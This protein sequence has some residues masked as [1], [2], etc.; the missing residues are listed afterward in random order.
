M[1]NANNSQDPRGILSDALN[2]W[3]D[4][5]D[6]QRNSNKLT[7]KEIDRLRLEVIGF[8]K[9]QNLV[10]KETTDEL[11]KVAEHL[12]NLSRQGN[13]ISNDK[14]TQ[15]FETQI[16]QLFA[17]GNLQPS[18]DSKVYDEMK[19]ALGNTAKVMLSLRE[20][21]IQLGDRISTQFK[22]LPGDDDYE[23]KHKERGRALGASITKLAGSKSSKEIVSNL[24]EVGKTF[25]N[26]LVGMPF[27]G[28]LANT[29]GEAVGN[30]GRAAFGDAL[31]LGV[32]LLLN[33]IRNIVGPIT[34]GI[35]GFRFLGSLK[36]GTQGVIK[37]L[38]DRMSGN[39]GKAREMTREAAKQ[40]L[41]KGEAFIEKGT[42]KVMQI[43]E[44]VSKKTGDIIKTVRPAGK[45]VTEAVTK[46]ASSK[47]AQAGFKGLKTLSKGGIWG[48]IG[49]GATYADALK[50][51]DSKGKAATKAIVSHL[52]GFGA[53]AGM[54]AAGTL[55]GTAAAPGVGT[56]AGFIAS[57][58]VAVAGSI[59]TQAATYKF[60]DKIW[61]MVD[62]KKKEDK[63]EDKEKYGKTLS[64]LLDSVDEQNE[65][66]DKKQGVLEKFFDWLKS[67]WPWSKE[68]KEA[69][70]AA[71][72]DKL[73]GKSGAIVTP[74]DG[75]D[76]Q[77]YKNLTTSAAGLG[78]GSGFDG[79]KI[80]S[81]FGE[82]IHPVYGT[83]KFH[84]GIDLAY[85]ANESVAAKLGG[86]ITKM[87]YQKGYGNVVYIKDDKTGIEQRI[88]HLNGF[89]P[90]MKVGQQISAGDII[91]AAGNT[92]V[93]TGVHVHYET[94][95]N[96][97]AVDPIKTITEERARQGIT[98]ETV[99]AHQIGEVSTDE[100]IKQGVYSSSVA[101]KPQG[102]KTEN[103]PAGNQ[104]FC[105]YVGY[106]GIRSQ[107][108]QYQDYNCGSRG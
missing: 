45:K 9:N 39:A 73:G 59:A 99:R 6:L 13:A 54:K 89:A 95:K 14:A 19:Q 5:I 50:E 40:S 81:M 78:E 84:K 53:Y 94:R 63:G 58:P 32:L 48:A 25:M 1:A 86:K 100:K 8:L 28:K 23:R 88:A 103:D 11:K 106:S 42:G 37:G 64:N 61:D 27:L 97:V 108:A 68:N 22:E 62:G 90:G 83:K 4:D 87:E 18:G 43:G 72:E 96:G 74:T 104:N 92:G 105:N 60:V 93:G 2:L 80:T 29:I 52:A 82:R 102:P 71:R 51:G 7:L 15:A 107:M 57:E 79:H 49:A 38:W 26:F 56:A 70:E 101:D 10:S 35:Q 30:L 47:A 12:K 91:G 46:A 33:G 31:K 69:R 75:S 77:L 65:K 41:K 24:W 55:A 3:R 16:M 98:A 66:E 85:K 21:L 17:S 34:A 20:S 36:D 44:R 76:K 67:M